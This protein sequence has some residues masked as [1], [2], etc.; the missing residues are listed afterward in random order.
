MHLILHE[1]GPI[2]LA[3]E[4]FVLRTGGEETPV[5]RP[6]VFLCRCGASRRKPFCDGSHA[7]IGFQAPGGELTWEAGNP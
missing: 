2:E 3:G 6:R 4:Q 5:A 7:R 1:N